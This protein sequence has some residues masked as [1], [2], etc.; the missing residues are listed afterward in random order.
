MKILLRVFATLIAL[1]VI[2]NLFLDNSCSIQRS[3]E[4]KSPVNKVFMK[5]ANATEWQNWDYWSELDS[6]ITNHYEGPV[7]GKGA[8]RSWTSEESGCGNMIFTDVLLNNR[9]DYDLNFIKPFKSHSKGSFT[10]EQI[11][12]ITKVSWD[13]VQ[14]LPFYIRMFGLFIEQMIGTAFDE[15]LNNLKVL[16]ETEQET[17]NILMQNKASFNYYSQTA[18]C[19]VKNIGKTLEQLY[20]SIYQN[21]IRDEADFFGRPICFYHNFS[22]DSVQLEAALPVLKKSSSAK[23]VAESVVI[24]ATYVGPYDKT[25]PAYDALD[26]FVSNNELN[27]SPTHYQVFITD[28]GEVNDPNKWVTEIYY[29]LS[30]TRN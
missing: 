17:F 18:T 15:S 11:Q 27:V 25:Q 26:Q 2:I 29:T 8:T 1:F 14:E 5:I 23:T 3:V 10:F 22:A 20:G 9:I 4:I 19:E 13:D 24:K 30:N 16:C 28:P 21:I 6:T 12:G 7:Y